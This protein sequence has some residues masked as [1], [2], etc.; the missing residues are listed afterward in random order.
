MK[1]FPKDVI[2]P[3]NVLRVYDPQI[4]MEGFLVIDNTLAGPGKG[5]F[6]MTPDV[7]AEEVARLARAMTLKNI[8]AGVPFGGAKA[9]IVWKGGK[10]DLE[11]KEKYVRSFTRALKPFLGKRYISAPDVNVGE[12]E[13]RWLVDEAKD[14][15]AA[16]G[17]PANLCTWKGFRKVCGIPHELGSTGF[18]VAHATRQAA[19]A[20]DIDIKGARIAIHGFGNVAMFAHKFLREMGAITVAVANSK[21]G[22]FAQDGLD[23]KFLDEVICGKEKL[24]SCPG[25]RLPL[26]KFWEIESDI[27]IPASVT[28][29][30]NESNK[31]KIKTKL[32][33]EGANI[34]MRENIEDEFFRRGIMIVPDVVAN[35]GGV[36]SSYAEYKG[37]THNQMFTLIKEKILPIT[38]EVIEKS[39]KEKTNPRVVAMEIASK[40]LSELRH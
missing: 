30:I 21:Y 28:D 14:W 12:R 10:D 5:G 34:P 37:M 17:K 39:V 38:K 32:I 20:L 18:G 27:L 7:T 1:D 11:L 35:S 25:E 36:I 22:L 13:I 9:G 24:D 16:T 40:R 19:E 31:D 8:L 33:V 29:V 3:E 2:G 6:R 26:E 15:N 23:E 4:G